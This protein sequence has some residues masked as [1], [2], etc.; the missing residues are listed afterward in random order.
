MT[1]MEA[2]DAWEPMLRRVDAAKAGMEAEHYYRPLREAYE[3]ACAER[4]ALSA[5][6]K[7][8]SPTA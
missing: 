6:I 5:L 8:L 1:L 2:L 7:S 3:A 4:D